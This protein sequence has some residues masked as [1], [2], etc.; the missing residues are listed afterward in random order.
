LPKGA[1]ALYPFI[2]I[3]A[4][5]PNQIKLA[6]G[7]NITFDGSNPD[8]RYDKGGE[9]LGIISGKEFKKKYLTTISGF[10]EK[11]FFDSGDDINSMG[12]VLGDGIYYSVTIDSSNHYESDDY[13]LGTDY[14]EL[15]DS[16]KIILIN[17][18]Q[19]IG[20]NKVKKLA[21]QNKADGA[22]D[23]TEGINNNPYLGLAIYNPKVIS[24]TTFDGGNPDIRYA[25]G[26][27][28]PYNI[29]RE[30]NEY[31][32]KLP[33]FGYHGTQ[34]DS[35]VNPRPSK[36]GR[37]GEG[38][39]LTLD[40]DTAE[41]FGKF[42]K[43]TYSGGYSKEYETA[44]V[45]E[46]DLRGLNLKYYKRAED[47][48]YI[49]FDELSKKNYDGIYLYDEGEI[50][51]FNIHKLPEA[52]LVISKK[53]K[54]N[55]AYNDG[56]SVLLAPNGKPSNLTPEQYRLVR[57][58]EFKAWFGDWENDPENSSKVVDENGEPLV[59]Y[60]GTRN[61]TQNVSG[62]WLTKSKQY[63]EGF[64]EVKEYFVKISNPMS[65]EEFNK[66]WM[67]DFTKYDGRL[68]DF[69][70]IVV[71]DIIQIK[72]ADGTN[73]TFD[74]NN[75]DIRFGKGGGLSKTPA[76]KKERIY[77]SKINKPFSA[78]DKKSAKS[79]KL[80]DSVIKSIN[81]IL[82]EHNSKENSTKI[83]LSTAKA[84]VRRGMG[85]YSSTH[86]PT[87]TGGKPN[88]RV[89][90]GLARLNAFV[91]KVEKGK[92][93]SGKYNQDDDLIKELKRKFKDGGRVSANEFVLIDKNI[94]P[95]ETQAI[96]DVLL[97][98]KFSKIDFDEAV[99]L[100]NNF[101]D[102]EKYADEY[103]DYQVDFLLPIDN[104]DS[105]KEKEV[106]DFLEI[107]E[108]NGFV[109]FDSWDEKLSST[110]KTIDFID[111]VRARL[112]TIT[113]RKQGSDLFPEIESEKIQKRN[114][115]EAIESLK[116]MK[117][118]EPEKASV[119]DDAIEGL[120]A[121]SETIYE[122]GG[123]TNIKPLKN[124][125]WHL[126]YEGKKPIAK[127]KFDVSEGN[128]EAITKKIDEITDRGY[129]IKEVSEEEFRSFRYSDVDPEDLKKFMQ[130]IEYFKSGGKIEFDKNDVPN[131]NIYKYALN[132]KKNYPEIWKKGGNIFGNQAFEN[133]E[134]VIKRGYWLD[135]E[136][137]MYVK[138][139]AYVA[140]HQRDYRIEGVI[141]MLKWIDEVEKGW[142]YMKDL[143][144]KYKVKY[145]KMKDGGEIQENELVTVYTE[146]GLS[147]DFDVNKELKLDEVVS[148]CKQKCYPDKLKS[149]IWKGERYKI[150]KI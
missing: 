25:D 8:I 118:L 102:Y 112:Q 121:Y 148:I 15:A 39:Y 35:L 79:I 11:A 150:E 100:Y 69:H 75:P 93:K 124:E 47:M 10:L 65:E 67:V 57:T 81:S 12:S 68:G 30:F 107:I 83:P 117:E 27:E 51:I 111:S 55:I 87:I 146:K 54:P 120:I 76:P 52:K 103:G 70:K 94:T 23:T 89:A 29:H 62:F 126:V 66:T 74:Y 132:I 50:V 9:V 64:G 108:N 26:G 49:E 95:D 7:S 142:A 131:K 22:Y 119:Y 114:A 21:L 13:Y 71:K 37:Y 144:E 17:D 73:T 19:T 98:D 85:A 147:F 129:I 105:E 97:L 133:L 16:A 24:N 1:R 59:V 135:S 58:P 122:N 42:G 123:E 40:A 34:S 140:R 77:G 61:N 143:I 88:S 3:V 56:G 14:F 60:R 63:A 44:N 137:W 33:K 125:K 101:K 90:W 96:N 20:G 130:G 78:S 136:A 127:M 2:E 115:L 128:F 92:S 86:R 145:K 139:R 6:D 5:F 106:K 110:G 4:Y 18:A 141:A 45:F 84:V 43:D 36:D 32:D 104:D 109:Y 113:L 82:K 91:Y 53:D 138:W 28:L 116:I 41:Y 80:D 31:I 149:F 38:F 72:L 99:F 134:R 48:P 46:F